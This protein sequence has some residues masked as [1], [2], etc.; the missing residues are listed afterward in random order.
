MKHVNIH[1]L[2]EKHTFPETEKSLYK[3]HLACN[4][5]LPMPA[6]G[7]GFGACAAAAPGDALA[8][9]GEA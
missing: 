1:K 3:V 5:L 2:W 7:L 6:L 9:R 8:R 4:H